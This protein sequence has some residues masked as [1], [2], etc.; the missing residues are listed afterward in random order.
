MTSPT[1]RP[2]APVRRDPADRAQLES[3]PVPLS[4]IAALFGPHRMRIAVVVALI[5]AASVLGLATPFLTRHIIDVALPE[6]DVGLLAA[7]LKI[8]HADHRAVGVLQRRGG[9][10]F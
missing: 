7:D 3:Y 10:R 4:R 8:G 9:I 1:F 5:A 6:Q 2:H